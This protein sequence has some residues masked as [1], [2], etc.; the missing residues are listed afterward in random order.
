MT[1][2]APGDRVVVRYAKGEGA[3]GDWRRDPSATRSDV[4]G[5]LVSV[6][7][8]A[9]VVDRDGERITV[10]GDLVLAVRVLPDRAVRTSEIRELEA[11]AAHGWPGTDRETVDG[12]LL[13]AGGG[14][15]RRANSA[16]PLSFGARADV[17]ILSV[18]RRWY[19]DHGLPPLVTVPDRV[20]P[21]G[22]PADGVPQ[23]RVVA[24]TRDIPAGPRHVAV[25]VDLSPTPSDAWSETVIGRRDE[26]VDRAVAVDVLRSVVDGTLLFASVVVDGVVVATG[27]G[28][29]TRSA[30]AAAPWLGL[31]CLWTHPDH[32]GRGIGSAVI[33][34]LMHAARG[35]G[36]RRTYL[37]VEQDNVAAIRL[38]RRLGFA[39]H[40]GYGYVLL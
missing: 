10:P 36:C 9:I 29:I 27:R 23:I 11:A 6:D 13:R 32:R 40:H 18:I 31:S 33:T 25:P 39:R 1:V 12:W 2:G 35:T 4:T 5:T 24:M 38:Y 8:D 16:V 26:V 19:D 20:L 3:P 17:A 15:T 30:E 28:A 21:P 37:Q 34:T 14:Y 7:A 22:T